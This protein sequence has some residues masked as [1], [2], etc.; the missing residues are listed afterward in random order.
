MGTLSKVLVLLGVAAVAALL[1]IGFLPVPSDDCGSAF[2][3]V[4]DAAFVPVA[5][6]ETYRGQ[7][8]ADFFYTLQQQ[9]CFQRYRTPRI[10]AG[11]LGVF[12]LTPL[13]GSSIP[14]P[15]NGC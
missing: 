3:P 2:V 4:A 6:A 13:P 1:F 9:A 15:L 11:A 14:L 5:D 10:I 7:T 12:A 8:D